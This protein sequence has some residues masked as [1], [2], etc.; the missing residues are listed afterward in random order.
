[1]EETGV[2]GGNHRPT[3]RER[4]GKMEGGIDLRDG[5]RGRD[6]GKEGWRD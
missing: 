5:W 3:A 6:L 2:P 1:M 4:E